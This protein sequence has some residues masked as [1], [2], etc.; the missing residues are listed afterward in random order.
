[1]KNQNIRIKVDN[2]YVDMSKSEINIEHYDLKDID[3]NM[4]A[5]FKA[6]PCLIQEVTD[7][8]VKSGQI[9][10]L[11]DYLLNEKASGV[12]ENELLRMIV[13]KQRRAA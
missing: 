12:G 11:I 5:V 6:M 8:I 10:D 4:D 7:Y 3:G 2:A 1:M 9:D 13:D